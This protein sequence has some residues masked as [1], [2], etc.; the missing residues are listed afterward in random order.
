MPIFQLRSFFICPLCEKIVETIETK[1]KRSS[2]TSWGIVLKIR[3]Q[4]SVAVWRLRFHFAHQVLCRERR[5][6]PQRPVEWGVLLEA[7]R[8]VKVSLGPGRD[9]SVN[10]C[11]VVPIELQAPEIHVARLPLGTHVEKVVR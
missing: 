3:H 2:P 7:D 9:A 11:L 1:L 8:A 4:Y 10:P 6:L 5:V